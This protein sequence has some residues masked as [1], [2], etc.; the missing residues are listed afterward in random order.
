MFY[1]T[2]ISTLV[3]MSH[4]TTTVLCS[5]PLSCGAPV[6]KSRQF[7][8]TCSTLL[9]V[10]V[11][12]TQHVYSSYV[13]VNA[14]QENWEA[15]RGGG[16]SGHG[17]QGMIAGP[18]SY[19]SGKCVQSLLWET[20]PQASPPLEHVFGR[21]SS[22]YHCS[23]LA[24]SSSLSPFWVDTCIPACFFCPWLVD[25]PDSLTALNLHLIVIL[26]IGM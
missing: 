2:A 24:T 15:K 5:S 23:H 18:A 22:V 1:S 26:S 17:L 4:H 8:A 20:K 13:F 7:F 21:S 16:G 9:E 10:V 19:I 11:D 6:L 12:S 14:R 25:I 3:V